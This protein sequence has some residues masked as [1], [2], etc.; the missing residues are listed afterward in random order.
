[1][2]DNKIGHK[3]KESWQILPI[4]YNFWKQTKSKS[5]VKTDFSDSWEDWI[6]R[7][8][9][10]CQAKIFKKKFSPAIALW[11]VK[12]AE[13]SEWIENSVQGGCFQYFRWMDL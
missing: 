6:K 3:T 11:T 7:K 1:M 9:P 2:A 8:S 13:H 10:I 12:W 5:L 4:L